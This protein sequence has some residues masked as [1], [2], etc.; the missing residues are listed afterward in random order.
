VPALFIAN[1]L[2]KYVVPGN[3]PE[4]LPVKLPEPEPFK[5]LLSLVVGFAS[6]AQHTPRAVTGDPPS[7]VILPPE[8]AVVD[9]ISVIVAV[10]KVAI[11]ALVVKV[12]SS[13]YAVP[14]AFVA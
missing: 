11:N 3:N 14:A 13:P 8:V 4:R 12:I 6:V 2:T 10:V 1:A 5:V 7:L 9:V